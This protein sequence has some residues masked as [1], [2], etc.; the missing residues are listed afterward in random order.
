[1][2]NVTLGL[3]KKS[4]WETIKNIHLTKNAPL[5]YIE[6]K[7]YYNVFVVW[8]TT[9]FVTNL[10][11]PEY[12]K[13]VIGKKSTNND[14][15]WDFVH[16]FKSKIDSNPP[17]TNPV[18]I[19]GVMKT[20]AKLQI[21]ESSRPDRTDKKYVS[22]WSGVGDD[23][24]NHV[25]WGGPK[26]VIQ[27][28]PGIA[29]K[30]VDFSFDPLFGEVW[31]HEGY[32]MWEGAGFGDAISVHVMAPGVQLQTLSNLDLV[33]SAN[34]VKYSSSGPGTGTHG[35]ASIPAP[36]PVYDSTGDWNID[37]NNNLIPDFSGNGKYKIYTEEKTVFRFL[38]KIPI[39][40]TT[41]SYTMLQ[42]ADSSQLI[43]PYFVRLISHNTSNSSWKIWF[44]V[45]LYR[46]RT[47]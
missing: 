42:S 43:H 37:E 13:E 28:E 40:G 33:L 8:N 12:S 9:K 3:V 5:D 11:K 2:Q 38:E 7:K 18:N 29:T 15:Y 36:V 24:E 19:S 4:D 16:H 39:G 41:Y 23:V 10:F 22:C 35:F 47:T 14:D 6:F 46:E 20:G 26:L 1:M 34:T 30:T 27:N 21:H 25:I 31:I 32:A 44:F 45:T 17:D